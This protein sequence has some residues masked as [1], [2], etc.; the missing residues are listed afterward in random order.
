MFFYRFQTSSKDDQMSQT[1]VDVK[2][3]YETS[4]ET[5]FQEMISRTRKLQVESLWWFFN[6]R[7]VLLPHPFLRMR[8][9]SC[10]VFSVILSCRS[11][12][13]KSSSKMH[14]NAVNTCLHSTNCFILVTDTV[15]FTDLGKLICFYVLQSSILPWDRGFCISR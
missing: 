14:H 7:N 13:R 4:F 12:T 10:V 6:N 9:R 5:T 8:L 1:D 11:R 2:S 3:I 15:C